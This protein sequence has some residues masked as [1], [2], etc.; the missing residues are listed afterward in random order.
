MLIRATFANLYSFD[1]PQSISFVAGKGRTLPTHVVKGKSRNDPSLLKAAIVYGANASGKSNLVKCFAF[2]RRLIVKGSSVDE[3]IPRVPFRLRPGAAKEPSRFEFELDLAGHMYAYKLVFDDNVIIEESLT[4][5]LATTERPLFVRTWTGTASQVIFSE[6]FATKE[7]RQ[8]FQFI[9]QNTRPN[10]PF[11]TETIESNSDRY[12]PVYD[13]FRYGL[14]VIY[15]EAI[16][17]NLGPA[18][19]SNENLKSLYKSFF[20]DLGL[21]IADIKEVPV[22]REHFLKEIPVEVVNE[23]KKDLK[24]DGHVTITG[25][26]KERYHVTKNQEGDLVPYKI[27]IS[28]EVAGT[29]EQI[30]FELKDESDG[31]LRLIDL[32]PAL[33]DL[34]KHERLYVIDE[35]DRSMHAQLTRAFLEYFFSCSTSRS[36]ILA[37]THELDLLDLELLRK[38]EIWFVEKDATSASN[39]YS[40]EEFKPRYDKDIRKGYLQGRFG[41]IPIIRN[42]G[43]LGW[44]K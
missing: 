16:F 27:L 2:A 30:P 37:T 38:D 21:G 32:I 10:Q 35:L 25:S 40:L 14:V 19:Q 34:C 23:I 39:L 11:L 3:R 28:H 33:A 1:T 20:R 15:P 26:P 44:E 31:T 13:W 4:R 36:Q 5:I 43:K 17:S 22:E 41:G 6:N 24:S 42:P 29:K 9:A 7:E 8:R 12:R 18:I